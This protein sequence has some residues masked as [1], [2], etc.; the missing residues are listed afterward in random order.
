MMGLVPFQEET[1]ESLLFS[2]GIEIVKRQLSVS[3]E[4][5]PY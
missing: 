5:S 4:Q 1:P 3:Q 2:S